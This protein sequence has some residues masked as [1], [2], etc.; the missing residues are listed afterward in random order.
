LVGG[1]DTGLKLPQILARFLPFVANARM[2]G[3]AIV[4]VFMALA[5]L[6]AAGL[7]RAP[8]LRRPAIQWLL[9]AIVAFEYWD[10]P[11]H[12]TPLDR[13]AVYQAL[14]AAPPGAV[15]EVPFGIG[16]GLSVGFGS[17]DRR[18]LFYATQHEHPLV[19]GYIGRMPPRAKERIDG[20][21]V[22]GPLLALSSSPAARVAPGAPAVTSP[23]QTCRYLVV[24]RRATPAAVQAYVQQL[25]AERIASDDSR[26]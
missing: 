22:A 5:V 8:R 11:I 4:V 19:G 24:N 17:Q 15:C 10:A 21:A 12:L 6:V 20:M 2:P 3:R 9:I 13:P 14:A 16:D 23:D 25:P 26:D 7:A 18:I 1:F